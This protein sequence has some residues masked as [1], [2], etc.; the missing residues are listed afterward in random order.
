MFLL[1]IVAFENPFKSF[2]FKEVFDIF[3]NRNSNDVTRLVL[4][5]IICFLVLTVADILFES[6]VNN[7]ISCFMISLKQR[8]FESVIYNNDLLQEKNSTSYL[9]LLLNDLKII[10]TNYYESIF[11][12]IFNSV[13]LI[14]SLIALF[15]LN[16]SM[17]ILLI[18]VFVLPTLIP[19][20]TKKNIKKQTE[21]WTNKNE[22]YTARVRD[23]FSGIDT[24]KG[25]GLEE[26]VIDQNNN[27]NSSV[28]QSYAK[29]NNW[30]VVTDNVVGL[31]GILGFFFVNL[32]G[33]L[34]AIK[35]TISLGTVV[36][37]IQLSN[38]VMNPALTIFKEYSKILTTK[39]VRDRIQD[40][41]E[42][43]N[44]EESN[45]KEPIKFINELICENISYSIDG[46][47]I[48]SNINI[49][50]KRGQKILITGPSG[51]GKSTLL[52]I[53]QKRI[54]NYSGNIFCDGKDIKFINTLSYYKIIS[55][56]NQR[57]FLFDDTLRNNVNLGDSFSDTDI[58]LACSRAGLDHVI[59]EKGLDYSVGE[60]G[61]YL[62][63]G[64]KQRIEIARA[65]LRN[66]SILLMD[67]ATSSLD[68]ETAIEIE[69]L[70][71][72]DKNLTVVS[73][74]HH[75]DYESLKLYDNI[76]VL[77]DGHIIEKG[78]YEKMSKNR[79]SYVHFLL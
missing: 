18:L 79:Q 14:A 9:S 67:E 49:K 54:Q 45:D 5:V 50:I 47:K 13:T 39:K 76:I 34:I 75:V 33:I 22:L 23:A 64:Q 55:M 43:V 53:L 37:I 17:S 63:G 28:E 36:A 16:I 70:I 74:A 35:G 48:L 60:D 38:T 4:I 19:Y 69:Q 41:I 7:M 15:Y 3:E 26:K 27:Y 52:R 73:V 24:I 46:K 62:S 31:L 42:N 20:I 25:Y 58:I 68:K 44:K 59:Y 72:N 29:L 21:D 2:V 57:P 30:R 65:F 8:I 11:N 61:K 77:L 51:S 71:L 6:T 78:N 40:V 10:Q 1:P 56:I 66:R 32:Y 12:I